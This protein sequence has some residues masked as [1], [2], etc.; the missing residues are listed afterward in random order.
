MGNVIADLRTAWRAIART[1]GSSAAIVLTCALAIVTAG[2]IFAIARA[3]L[4]RPLPFA[5]PDRLVWIWATRIDRDRAFFSM[6]DFVEQAR[7]TAGMADLVAIANWGANL[8]TPTGARRLQGI[9]ATAT[10]ASVLGIRPAAGRSLTAQDDDPARPLVAMLSFGVWR[11]SF[12]ADPSVVGRRAILNETPYEI[13]G[14]LPA[15][16]LIPGSD[17]DVLVPLRPLADPRRTDYGTNFLR[18]IGRLH[19]G[20]SWGTLARRMAEI[21]ARLRTEFPDTNAKKTDPRVLTLESEVVG[22]YRTAFGLL[23]FCGA[24]MVLLTA[25]NLAHVMLA[26][27]PA[28][29]RAARVRLALGGS[30][31]HVARVIMAEPLI[32]AVGSAA[33]GLEAMQ[34]LV[35]LAAARIPQVPR[36]A[37]AHAD[38]VTAAV[39]LAAAAL[40]GAAAG[41][42]PVARLFA[43][44]VAPV[45]ARAHSSRAGAGSRLLALE[46]ALCLTLLSTAILSIGSLKAML[47]VDTGLSRGDALAVR[48]ALPPRYAVPQRFDP[49]IQ[50]LLDGLATRPEVA[51]AAVANVLPLSGMNVRT[52]F[53]IVG[54][55]AR[56]ATESPGSQ[57]RWVSAQYFDTAGI[58]ILRGRAFTDSDTRAAA[59]VAI[60]DAT[61]ARQYWGDRD[62]IGEQIQMRGFDPLA[63]WT[64]VGVS[65]PVKHQSIDEPASGTL[66]APMAQVPD[67]TL[68]F[69]ANSFSLIARGRATPPE[70]LGAL[71]QDLV[72][73]RDAA[74]PVAAP[75]PLSALAEATLAPRRLSVLLA[76]ALAA[77]ALLIAAFGVWAVTA[78]VVADR[79]REFAIRLA[80]GASSGHVWRVALRVVARAAI[81][82]VAIGVTAALLL[83]SLFARVFVVTGTARPSAALLAAAIV[84]GAALAGAAG[85]AWRATAI[86]PIETLRQE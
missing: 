17:T 65:G 19:A 86:D 40:A 60:V 72:H 84:T 64:I 74:V 29:E 81:A 15:A 37:G 63:R 61:L 54:H 44:S 34:W 2:T 28:T 4:L 56:S 48:I 21:N 38:A 50:G 66:Y 68:S 80:I 70:R 77:A 23:L 30:P 14:V 25:A 57:N 82:G 49:F 18:V 75:R 85:P 62:P 22:A 26:R 8:T 33:I 10:I 24:L 73:A 59:R 5:D 78:A 83:Q 39:V 7:G 71:L 51:S 42:V 69:V 53:D 58:P 79:R 55:P 31:L 41:A 20:T 46:V 35:P 12:G 27:L 1:P 3:V 47:A 52:D 16:F 11:D 6:P 45:S 9:R 43:A 67:T 36:A 13:V 32:L 76:S